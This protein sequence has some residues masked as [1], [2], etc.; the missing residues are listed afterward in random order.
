MNKSL[1]HPCIQGYF[2]QYLQTHPLLSNAELWQ[3]LF[4]ETALPKY[5]YFNYVV[6]QFLAEDLNLWSK[7]IISRFEKWKFSDFWGPQK[8]QFKAKNS[9]KAKKAEI[10]DSC[11]LS[12]LSK[13]RH[14]FDLFRNILLYL[15][16]TS[17]VVSICSSLLP[18]HLFCLGM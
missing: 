11:P 12:I 16:K 4:W 6:R 2:V 15:M 7:L 14:W 5:I 10:L 8:L 18:A 17:G 1:I 13:T 9:K 3:K